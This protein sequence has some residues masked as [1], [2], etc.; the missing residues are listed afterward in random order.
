MTGL[1]ELLNKIMEYYGQTA[2]GIIMILII[3][4][5]SVYLITKNYSSVIKAYLERRLNEKDKVHAKAAQHRKS[6]T[7]KVRK[8]LSELA[9]DINADRAIVF[10]YSNGSTNLVGLP[11]LYVS[12]TCEVV[13]PST[14]P[15]SSR[16]QKLNTSI[17]AQ[18]LEVLEDK[19]YFYVED[20]TELRDEHPIIYDL[21]KPNGVKSVLF[22]ILSGVDDTIGFICVTTVGE[23]YFTRG[24]S[25]PKT[26]AMAQRI[27]S[28]LNFDKLHE[29]L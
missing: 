4:V 21:M 19:G 26:A 29:D 27:S 23:N 3:L 22:Y 17:I 7:P 25:L 20:L 9:E 12:A 8:E 24:Q 13:T 1:I 2:A 6:V 16:Y 11:F 28:Y 18:F 10:E 15:V 5:Y 14:I